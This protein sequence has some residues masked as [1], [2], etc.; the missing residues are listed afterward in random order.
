MNH[1]NC[2]VRKKNCKIQFKISCSPDPATNFET[3]NP[4]FHGILGQFLLQ[5]GFVYLPLFFV[6]RKT[7]KL[8]FIFSS[9]VFKNFVKM[10]NS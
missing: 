4:N 6:K 9:K 7:N 5:D 2:L 1:R 8:M 10:K 3:L